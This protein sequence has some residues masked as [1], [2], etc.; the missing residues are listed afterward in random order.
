MTILSSG[1]D[2]TPFSKRRRAV[3][4]VPCGECEHKC[5]GRGKRSLITWLKKHHK[6]TLP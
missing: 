6:D 5:I 4:E 3:Y 1:K 2:T